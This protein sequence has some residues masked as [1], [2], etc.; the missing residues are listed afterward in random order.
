MRDLPH[1]AHDAVRVA[2]LEELDRSERARDV[3][4]QPLEFFHSRGLGRASRCFEWTR[5]HPL[6][7]GKL[8]Q[9]DDDRV[10]EV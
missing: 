2:G 6:C 10:G 9:H 7:E 8:V 4:E 1:R 3:G 5:L